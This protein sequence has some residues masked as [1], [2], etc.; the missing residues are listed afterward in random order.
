MKESKKTKRT[1]PA[2]LPVERE[3][4]LTRIRFNKYG[5]VQ[6][7]DTVITRLTKFGLNFEESAEPSGEAHIK[8]SLEFDAYK[9]IIDINL[10][11][12]GHKSALVKASRPAA[13]SPI[14]DPKP[15]LI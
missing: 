10:N 14:T 6:L 5:H 9:P 8:L 1:V 15:S 11:D 2:P 13:E 7:N 4:E 12:Y 3:T